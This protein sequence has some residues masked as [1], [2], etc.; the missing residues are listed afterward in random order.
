MT[1]LNTSTTYDVVVVGLGPTGATLANLLAIS[2]L[3]VAI[4][5]REAGQ[6]HLPRAVHFD[7]ETMRVFQTVG[8]GNALSKKL[9][10]N[11][12]MRF[13]DPDGALLLDWPRPQEVGPHG[14]HSSYRFHQPDL[15]TLLRQALSQREGVT[16][17]ANCEVISLAD[18]GDV[19]EI[20]CLDRL[21]GESMHLRAGYVVGCDGAQS[22]VRAAIGSGMEDLGFRERW[23]VVDALLKRDRPDLGDHS[24]Q[25]CDPDRPMTYCRSPQN[26]R[27]WEIKV[28]DNE[29][30]EEIIDHHRVWELLS[31]WVTPQDADLERC[32]VYTFHSEI[33]KKWRKGRLLIAGDAAHLTPPFMGQGMCAGVR[34]ASNLGW[35][36]A[37]CAR[38]KAGQSLLDSYQEE[39][40]P[41]VLEYITT[42][43]RL[44]GLINSLDR[45]SALSMANQSSSKVAQ[46]RSIAPE[47]GPSNLGGLSQ[48]KSLHKGCLFA[49]P[50]LSTGQLMDDL[51]GYK[52]VL[53][54]RSPVQNTAGVPTLNASENPQIMA[55]LDALEVNAALVRP[56]RYI[57]ATANTDRS[58]AK[59][60]NISFPLS[61]DNL[62]ESESAA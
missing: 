31:K 22:T 48:G 40:G 30:D 54:T 11:L 58:I 29:A 35:K 8:I 21:T 3:N 52:P 61:I 33:A 9:H 62:N 13:M 16:I 42:A 53:I 55:C 59:L 49:Q 45:N 12:G 36:L 47:L 5:D 37:L 41:H 14:W 2:G 56:D 20:D 60:T 43:I 19:V 26:R 38:G 46:M 17:R 57:L 27:R 23:L 44:G 7:D 39:R 15:E 18:T 4:L 28:L 50:K 32:A 1:D 51:I 24:I 25:Y 6:Y 10:V 34:D